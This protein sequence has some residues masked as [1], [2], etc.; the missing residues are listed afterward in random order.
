MIQAELNCTH[1]IDKFITPTTNHSLQLLRFI[2]Q[3]SQFSFNNKEG[4]NAKI[5]QATAFN[6]TKD[7]FEI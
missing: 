3:L 4:N 5:A 7:K 6:V 2:R 1:P